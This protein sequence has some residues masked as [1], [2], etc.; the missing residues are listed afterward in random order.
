MKE[1]ASKGSIRRAFLV[2]SAEVLFKR[3]S[4][5]SIMMLINA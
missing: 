5:T 2:L 4:S 3:F 1:K